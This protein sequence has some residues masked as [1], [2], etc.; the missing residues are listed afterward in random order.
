MKICARH[1]VAGVA[2]HGDRDMLIGELREIRAVAA[3][4]AAMAD[5]ADAL[6]VPD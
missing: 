1:A 3:R 2:E 4:R 5:L 6:I